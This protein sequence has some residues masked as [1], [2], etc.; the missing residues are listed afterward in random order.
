M[1]V[2]PDPSAPGT[3]EWRWVECGLL[4]GP[5]RLVPGAP[6]SG[7]VVVVAPHPDDEILGAGG[8][9]ALLAAAGARIDLVAVTDGEGSHA[10][11]GEELIVTRPAESL[12]AACRL[13]VHYGAVTRLRQPDGEVDRGVVEDRLGSLVSRGDLVLAPWWRDGHPDHDATGAAATEAAAGTGAQLLHYLVWAW[14]WSEPDD[15]VIPWSR[16]VRVDLGA[17]LHARKADA[18]ACFET[19]LAGPDPI[20]PAHVLARLLRPF[21]ILV[22]AAR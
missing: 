12:A 21:E 11:R 8:T 20:L 15:G 13:R 16:T 7:R 18:V 1:S 9:L 4:D 5:A 19:Q 2:R 22:G 10:G 3:P 14:H 17:E 6:P